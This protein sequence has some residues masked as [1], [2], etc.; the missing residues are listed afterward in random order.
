MDQL[1]TPGLGLVEPMLD[2]FRSRYPDTAGRENAVAAALAGEAGPLLRAQL[3]EWII[4]L[5]PV[6]RLVPEVHQRWRPLVRD[7]MLFTV[8]RLSAARLAP[9]V[10]EQMEMPATTSAEM[11]LLRL[12]AKVPGLQKIG[13]VL[14][15]NRR[16]PAPLR[17]AL[18]ELENGIADVSA[19]EI[20]AIVAREL[21]D[22]MKTYRVQLAETILSEAS[23]SAVLRFTWRNPAGGRRERG[24]FKVLKPHIPDCFAEDMKILQE[25]AAHLARKYRKSEIRLAGLAETLTEIRL[26]L[27]HE[28]DFRREQSTLRDALEPYRQMP[29]VRVPR[30][31]QPLCTATVT[32]LTEEPG[33]KVT[34]AFRRRSAG[35]TG[36]ANRLAEALVGIPALA[37]EPETIYHAD[38]HAGNIL[39]DKRS[40]QLVILDW[41]LTERLTREHRRNVILL[42]LMLLLRDA[43]GVCRAVEGLR[44]HRTSGG[45]ALAG[46]IRCLVARRL[47]EWPLLRL[48]GGMDA[49][50]LLD[51]IALE[52]V[53]FPGALLMFRKAMFTLEG[54]L[55][56]VTSVT[57]RMDSAVARYAARHW[58]RTVRML[59][60]VLSI[61]D[62]LALDWSALTFFSRVCGQGW[63]RQRA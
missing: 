29:G 33:V 45:E 34:A 25:L 7:A 41:A 40:R 63:S 43:D 27:R 6:E 4:Q 50:R 58:D 59:Y 14:A 31:I 32:A 38:P 55:E 36:V 5:V 19:D 28:V 18:S 20:R 12:I 46:V 54:V 24:V 52:G 26:L 49:L 57:V 30:L 23:V 60:S 44:I 3:G 8:W 47:E 16:L 56:D 37:R 10:V 17:K 1:V 51:E 22:R 9:K 48:P 62:W 13:Q 2:T 53:Q 35:R 15:R 39:Y 11:R 42:V 61:R 21:G